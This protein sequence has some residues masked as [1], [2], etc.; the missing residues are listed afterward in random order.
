MFTI[1]HC[2]VEKEE[3]L[4]IF[5]VEYVKDLSQALHNVHCIYVKFYIKYHNK[6]FL[7]R[8]LKCFASLIIVHFLK[9]QK[10]I[11][12]LNFVQEK[13]STET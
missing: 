1:V 2:K 9:A 13:R 12:K 8:H 4:T 7:L 5:E 11:S 10:P 3:S 6:W